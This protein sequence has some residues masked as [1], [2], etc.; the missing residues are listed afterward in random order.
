MS[1]IERRHPTSRLSQLVMSGGFA[2]LAGQ[3]ADDASLDAA[4]QTRQILGKIDRLLDEAGA[5]RS[6][7]LWC[8]IFL[9]D[10]RHRDEINRE[11]QNWIDPDALPARTSV[12]A[13][14]ALPGLL[15]EITAIAARATA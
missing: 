11:W 5:C 14:L 4:G 3:V 15:V 9:A 8:I 6:D 2:F 12:E 13:K 7:L 1:G 10:I